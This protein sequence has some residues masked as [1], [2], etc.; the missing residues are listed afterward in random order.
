[1]IDVRTELASGLPRIFG[2]ESDIRDALTNL[3]FNA[4]DAMPDGGT[5]TLRTRQV[6]QLVELDLSDT[7]A[8]MDE[9][10]RRRCIE[11]FFTTKGERGTGMGLAMVYGMVQRH[12]AQIEID[13]A[14]GVGTTVR[15]Q[16]KA[17]PSVAVA[18]KRA[19]L[20]P[21]RPL[22]L[23]VIDDDPLVAQSLLH[24]LNHEGHT[25]TTAD[26][27]QAGID[28]F[29]TANKQA[30]PFD[31]VM[32]DLGMPYVDGRAVA[33]A[34]KSMSPRTPI[35]LLTGWGQRL[36]TEQTVPEHVDRLLSKPPKLAELSAALAEMTADT[37]SK[38]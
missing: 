31:V 11:P 29:A 36:S 15:L 20:R 35:L 3:V 10:T 8:G 13:S 38:G 2:T 28:A 6:G 33:A 9:E 12:D 5:L 16:F 7:G 26:G 18:P 24:V 37:D 22:N 27:G 23:L 32:T 1:V 4:V 34:I 30:R 17:A 19:V 25:V 21:N 14:L